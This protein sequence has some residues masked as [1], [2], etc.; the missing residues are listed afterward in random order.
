MLFEDL[1]RKYERRF[2][3]GTEEGS[4]LEMIPRR[5]TWFTKLLQDL[6]RRYEGAFPPSWEIELKLTHDFCERTQEHV[7][8]LLSKIDPPETAPV[9]ELLDSLKQT[10]KFEK[11]LA[12]RFKKGAKGEGDEAEPE[13][14]NESE[15]TKRIRMKY[16]G[17][18][19]GGRG[20]ADA[21]AAEAESDQPALFAGVVSKVFEPY[22]ASYVQREKDT[23]DDLVNKLVKEEREQ[24]ADPTAAGSLTQL[25]SSIAI[26]KSIEASMDRCVAISTGQTLFLV[27]E[28]F[29]S[30]LKRYARMLVEQ[31]PTG[32]DE[33]KIGFV[34]FVINTGVFCADT[35]P[36]LA[37][38]IEAKIDERFRGHISF[39]G[40]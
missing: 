37:E 21:A 25:N 39:D 24:S 26:F 9:R 17:G 19:G 7:A 3:D 30:C 1:M 16:G 22:L 34:C 20:E 13:R 40:E 12:T 8:H 5:Y 10:I 2:A 6:R 28:Q 29:K 4:Q 15:E 36:R 23:M 32:A 18:G 38:T 35:V 11:A 27:T 33:R 14:E 31:L